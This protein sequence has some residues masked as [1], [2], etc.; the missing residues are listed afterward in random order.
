M[1]KQEVGKTDFE[2]EMLT[3]EAIDRGMAVLQEWYA[4]HPDKEGLVI[5]SGDQSDAWSPSRIIDILHGRRSRNDW[6][7][8]DI[9]ELMLFSASK[10]K[11]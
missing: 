1:P 7:H 6:G 11:R 3:E 9:P 8:N 2:A 4:S 5:M 10:S